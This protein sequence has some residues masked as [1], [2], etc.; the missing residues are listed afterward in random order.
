[1]NGRAS[2]PDTDAGRV[3]NLKTL[4]HWVYLMVIVHSTVA[5]EEV[6]DHWPEPQPCWV[7]RHLADLVQ[8]QPDQVAA[9]DAVVAV[10]AA[11]D[12]AVAATVLASAVVAVVD[13]SDDIVA[14]G[15]ASAAGDAVFAVDDDA[16]AVAAAA[17]VASDDVAGWD[18][19]GG[20]CEHHVERF[21]LPLRCSSPRSPS[22]L[23]SLVDLYEPNAFM[24][25]SD[26]TGFF[27]F[28]FLYV[29]NSR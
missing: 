14:D 7:W 19:P 3:Q 9:R 23:V 13:A 15:A 17:A 16:V 5:L 20:T 25:S 8:A 29:T 18:F 4:G 1:M 11:V 26:F 12:V 6:S 24:Q 22:L 2:E 10:A 27:F 28:F 21:P